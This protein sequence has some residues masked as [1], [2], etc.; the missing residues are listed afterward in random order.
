MNKLLIALALILAT[1]GCTQVDTGNRGVKVYFGEVDEKEGSMKEGLYWYNPITTS[2]QELN[3]KVLRQEGKTNT[4]TRDVQQADITFVI[5]YRLKPDSAHTIF[6]EVGQAWEDVLLPQAIQGELKKVIGQYDAIDLVA[7]RGKATAQV[8]EAI[9]VSL[10]SKN[11]I[12][13]RFEM[14]NISYLPD[15]EKS[16]EHKQI[17]VQKAIEEV[18]RT[19]QV[20]EK[21][22]QTIISAKSEAESMRIRANALTQNAQLV[23]YEAVQKWDG[24]LPTYMLGGTVPFINVGK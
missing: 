10:V 3:V 24:K 14:T 20:E 16:V 23:Q 9:K 19:K 2:V 5:N 15:F 1:G 21:A 13:E 6:K 4:Y 12:V 18:N 7:H 17:A 22:K 8:E 11:V